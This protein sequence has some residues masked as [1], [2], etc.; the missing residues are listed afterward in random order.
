MMNNCEL[1]EITALCPC[2]SSDD[3]II[4]VNDGYFFVVK[5]K[6][7]GFRVY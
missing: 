7:C 3:V 6:E 5:C 2:C 4:E 1:E